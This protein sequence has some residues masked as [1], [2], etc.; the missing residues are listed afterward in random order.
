MTLALPV[1]HPTPSS[2]AVVSSVRY[3]DAV[4][5]HVRYVTTTARA[6]TGVNYGEISIIGWAPE[7]R[8]R[9][10]SQHST[11]AAADR[12]PL[13][14]P[15]PTY[16]A[17]VRRLMP[18]VPFGVGALGPVEPAPEEICRGVRF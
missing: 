6:I 4:A 1:R 13:V 12:M 14:A 7:P 15:T 9:H 11:L 8:S 5:E 18:V 3:A 2:D 16:T 10:L 17:S